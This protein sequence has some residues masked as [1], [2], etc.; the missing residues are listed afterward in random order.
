[1]AIEEANEAPGGS[2]WED[3]GPLQAALRMKEGFTVKERPLRRGSSQTLSY[4]DARDVMNRLDG[5]FG[6]F[7][8]SDAYRVLDGL[9]VECTITVHGPEGFINKTDV[10]YPNSGTDGH[11]NEALKAAYS[12]AFKR[13]A[14]K[15]GIG[16]FLYE[17][18]HAA[19]PAATPPMGAPPQEQPR[20]PPP[21]IAA[22]A[23]AI[24]GCKAQVGPGPVKV[25]PRAGANLVEVDAA[26]YVALCQERFGKVLCAAHLKQNQSTKAQ[27]VEKETANAK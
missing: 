23:C 19:S 2:R 16:R 27:E 13:A 3:Q 5:V 6:V 15:L 20:V 21:P 25:Q 1:M 9:A 12:D 26:R 24:D 11:E 10:G 8:W 14:V 22:V 17:D 18:K 4:I 7:G